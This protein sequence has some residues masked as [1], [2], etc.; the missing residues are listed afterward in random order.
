MKKKYKGYNQVA[1]KFYKSNFKKSERILLANMHKHARSIDYNY[2]EALKLRNLLV[3]LHNDIN[4]NKLPKYNIL[5][6]ITYIVYRLRLMDRNIA[7]TT[8]YQEPE[9]NN[10]TWQPLDFDEYQGED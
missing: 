8:K 2:K 4:K 5:Q 1:K 6:D 9:E 3:Q 10:D 7:D